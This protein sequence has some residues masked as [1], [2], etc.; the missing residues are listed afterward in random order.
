MSY[1]I[2]YFSEYEFRCGHSKPEHL[3]KW[4]HDIMFD[5][6]IKNGYEDPIPDDC[7]LEDYK[8]I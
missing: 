8:C 3:K 7:P 2:K 5:F 6:V 4:K 1:Y